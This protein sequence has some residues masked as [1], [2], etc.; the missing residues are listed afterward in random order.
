MISHYLVRNLVDSLNVE[1]NSE[2]KFYLDDLP[3]LVDPARMLALHPPLCSTS[4]WLIGLS[5]DGV[6]G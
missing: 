2:I 6:I 4:D 3:A 1:I 5:T